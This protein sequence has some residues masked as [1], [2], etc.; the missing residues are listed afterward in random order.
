VIRSSLLL[1]AGTFFWSTA[2]GSIL[3]V[4][5]FFNTE[6]FLGCVMSTFLITIFFLMLVGRRFLRRKLSEYSPWFLF[7]FPL[8]VAFVLFIVALTML[9]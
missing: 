8:P 2:A 3:Y 5:G 6:R 9:G 7:M 1:L 4:V